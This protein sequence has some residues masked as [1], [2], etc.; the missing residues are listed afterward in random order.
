MN[1]AFVREPEENGARYCP[2]CGSIGVPVSDE[3]AAAHLTQAA[4]Q[5]L[6]EPVYYCPFPKCGVAYFDLFDRTALVETLIDAAFP[7]DP[8]APLCRCFGLMPADVAEDVREGTVTRTRAIVERSKTPEAHCH[9]AA[10]DGRCC[11]PE[12]QRYYFRARGA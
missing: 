1:K 12:V 2:S 9:I 4:H 11:V 8:T 10:P 7:K 3:T 6:G 5:A